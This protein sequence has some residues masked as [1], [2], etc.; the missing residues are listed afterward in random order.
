MVE[1]KEIG[2]GMSVGELAIRPEKRWITCDGVVQQIGRLHQIRFHGTAKAYQEKIFGA[3]VEIEGGD[4]PRRGPFDR[5]L[6]PWRKL[7]LKL[8]GNPPRDF[9][10]NRE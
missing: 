9:T 5:V 1:A 6:F 7:G 2:R 4:V 8:L 10:L 3:R